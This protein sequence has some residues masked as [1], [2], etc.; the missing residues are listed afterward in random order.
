MAVTDQAANEAG[1][2][3]AISSSNVTGVTISAAAEQ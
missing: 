1:D 2:G 3:V